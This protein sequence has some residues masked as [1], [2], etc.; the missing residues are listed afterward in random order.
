MTN[1]DLAIAVGITALVV[2]AQFHTRRVRVLA[3]VWVMLLVAR[4][5]VPPGPSRATA[6]SIAVLVASLLMSAAFGVLRGRTMPLWRATDGAVYRRGDRTT[7]LLWLATIAAKLALALAAQQ[8]LR[9]P[10]NLDALW[11][12][13][14]VT[15]AAQQ[16]VLLSRAAVMPTPVRHVRVPAGRL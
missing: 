8:L 7:F 14:G 15:V 10:I 4:G 2:A 5:C 9:E 12:G 11:L 16:C 1:L 3:F 13:L 6:L